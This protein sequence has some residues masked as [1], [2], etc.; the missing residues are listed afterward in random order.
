MDKKNDRE[1]NRKTLNAEIMSY[2]R[3]GPL[4]KLLADHKTK[5]NNKET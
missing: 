2:L 4:Q 1:N 5:R 3:C